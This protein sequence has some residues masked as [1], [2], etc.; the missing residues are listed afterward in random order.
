MSIT[1]LNPP[2]PLITPLGEAWAHFIWTQG[3]ETNVHFGCFQ[4]ETG[5]NWWWENDKVRLCKNIS[6]G[7]VHL[8]DIPPVPGLE[9]HAKRYEELRRADN[10]GEK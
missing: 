4:V 7:H 6:V 5:E 2:L 8:T 1:Q 10:A 3:I 9:S